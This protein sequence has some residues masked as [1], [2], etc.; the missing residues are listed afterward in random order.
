MEK[1]K[2]IVNKW[3]KE[4]RKE[5]IALLIILMVGAFLRL[6][7]IS[8]YMTFLGDEGRDAI[9]VRRLLV[10]FDPILVGPGTSI[11]NMYLGPLYYYMMAPALLLANFSPV[12]PS[13][14]IAILGVIT[15]FLVWFIAREW[16]G[17]FA[18]FIASALY[19]VSPT[20]IIFSRHSWNPNIMPFFALLVIY[21]VWRIW[22]KGEFRWFWVLAI[23]FAFVLQSHYLGLVLGPLIAIFWFFS[24]LKARKAKKVKPLVKLSVLSAIIFLILMSPLVIFDARHGWRN[25]EAM[26]IFFTQRQTTVSARPWAALPKLWANISQITTRL[27]AARNEVW[28]VIVALVL[29]LGSVGLLLKSKTKASL[30]LI[31]VWLGLALLGLGIYKQHIYDHY[32]GFFFAAPFLLIGATGEYLI[33]QKYI[34]KMLV[35]IG[36]ILLLVFN[37]LNS[38]IKG[39]PN[40]QL[41][42][43]QEVAQKIQKEA[44]EEKFNL[45][46][47]A[48][49]NY[50]DAYQYF[51]ERWGTKVIDI[52]PLDFERTIANQ[53]FVVCEMPPEKCDP[54]HNAKA[55]IANFGWS[56]VEKEWSV[57]GVTLFKLIHTQ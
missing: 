36:F 4:N 15:I 6:Y 57:A 34:G 28:G 2:L 24:F 43:T 35:L 25:F 31:F 13:I 48:E 12:G 5:F 45:A 41:Q 39:P 10:N 37:L 11:G 38:P 8:E 51:L 32:Y 9:V 42:R 7:R 14:Q 50:E 17:K 21:S 56:K 33:S 16:F 18:G 53:L 3:I 40:R 19:A 23:A 47:I 1:I 52:D 55:E 20:V 49:R 46:V 29:I 26:K 44:G 22:Q 27:I 30:S 54:T